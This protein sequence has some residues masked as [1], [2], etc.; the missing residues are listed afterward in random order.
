MPTSLGQKREIYWYTQEYKRS[1]KRFTQELT[2]LSYPKYDLHPLFIGGEENPKIDQVGSELTL[3]RPPVDRSVDRSKSAVY[4]PVGAQC[5]SLLQD[6]LERPIDW[7]VD[8]SNGFLLYYL[9]RSTDVSPCTRRSAARSIK[10]LS[11]SLKNSVVHVFDPLSTFSTSVKIFKIWAKFLWTLGEV[12]TRSQL[13][14]YRKNWNTISIKST[15]DLDFSNLSEIDTWSRQNWHD[16]GFS[17]WTAP[18]CYVPPAHGIKPLIVHPNELH[19]AQAPRR[20][21]SKFLQWLNLTLGTT[22]CKHVCG[23][24]FGVNLLHLDIFIFKNIPQKCTWHQ[25]VLFLHDRFGF[26]LGR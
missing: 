2:F 11:K 13:E 20:I 22:Y 12:D 17:D 10:V 4:R 7:S 26:S 1:Y 5:S 24:I 18:L 14:P 16:F 21:Q 9:G 15:H 19:R 3:T 23:I 8:Q 6:L 25:H